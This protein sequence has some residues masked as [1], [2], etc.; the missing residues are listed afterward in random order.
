MSGNSQLPLDALVFAHFHAHQHLLGGS[1][2]SFSETMREVYEEAVPASMR[3]LKLSD[4]ANV[5]KRFEANGKR[6][7]RYADD[8]TEHQF[9]LVLLVP[10]VDAAQRLAPAVGAAL[11]TDICRALGSL[12]VPLPDVNAGPDVAKVSKLAKEF[13]EAISALAPIIEDGVFDER[14]APHI[15]QATEQLDDLI[16]AAMAIKHQ[17]GE[18]FAQARAEKVRAVR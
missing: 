6:L 17:L 18:V 12:Y 2:E 14:D 11:K 4:D 15:R 3:R 16:G 8:R 1:L 10:F 5:A 7:R 13:G 9:P